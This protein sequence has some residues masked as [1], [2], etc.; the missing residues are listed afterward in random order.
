MFFAW[1]SFLPRTRSDFPGGDLRTDARARHNRPASAAGVT[2]LRRYLPGLAQQS[3]ATGAWGY[4]EHD[5]DGANGPDNS[6]WDGDG[7]ACGARIG[8]VLPFLHVGWRYYDP[9]TG[10]FL[11]R[12]PIGIDGGLNVYQY[13]GAAPTGIVDPQGLYTIGPPGPGGWSWVSLPPFGGPHSVTFRT[14]LAHSFFTRESWRILAARVGVTG[15]GTLACYGGLVYG[16][17]ELGWRAG[18]AIDE[19]FGISDSIGRWAGNACPM[20]FLPEYWF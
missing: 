9:S 5:A 16:A 13:A 1:Q 10:R 20:C 18:T 6:V 15:V 7:C 8:E 4:Q 14:P 12:D 11:Q 3:V 2:E 17:A 19:E